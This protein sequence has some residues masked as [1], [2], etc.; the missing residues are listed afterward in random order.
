MPVNRNALIRYKTIDLCLQNR[1]RKWTLDDL[2]EACSE[3]LYE[4]EGIRKG[5]SQRTVQLDIQLMRSDKLGYN[6]PI[7]VRDK[8]FYAYEDPG[9]SIMNIPL[10]ENDLNKLMETVDFLKQFKGFSYFRELDTV[11]Q[12]LED[13]VYSKKINRKPVIDFEKNDNLKGLEFLEI[14]Y[15]S[16]VRKNII[17]LTYQSFTARQPQVFP[18]YPY[19]LKE[20]RNRWFLIGSK[21]NASPLLNLAI[22]RII[23]VKITEKIFIEKE[24]FDA[25]SYF[26]DV[27]GVTVSP[28]IEVETI[29][30]FV[31][32]KHAPY[33]LTKPFHPSQK[34]ISTDETGITISLAVQHNY[35]LEK[36]ILGLGD[37]IVVI[38]PERLKRDIMRRLRNSMDQYLIILTDKNLNSAK[39]NYFLKGYIIVHKL[40]TQQ[41]MDH[42]NL[43]ISKIKGASLAF[44]ED[45]V[46]DLLGDCEFKTI[47]LN[48]QLNQI[49]SQIGDSPQIVSVKLYYRFPDCSHRLQQSAVKDQNTVVVL[50]STLS[51]KTFSMELFPGSH[52]TTLSP[53]K[54]KS[55]EV[56]SKPIDY[57]IINGGAILMHPRLLWRFPEHLANEFVRIITMEITLN[58]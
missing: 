51:S 26:K 11:V 56:K 48:R 36:E 19:L 8:K 35:E 45:T 24:E 23:N 16:I 9:Y 46:I 41:D 49:L 6:A 14:L 47:L 28:G 20:F 44:Q 58:C 52:K 1:H 40:L 3:S 18:F 37:G 53:E 17:E 32:R 31:Y 43:C 38:S 10:S 39:Q 33:V 29:V 21:N 12:K 42:L 22:D 5:V 50:V 55:I 15:Q 7:V 13:H 30:L 57:Q 25:E 54:I 27:I 4:Y 2:V 34:L